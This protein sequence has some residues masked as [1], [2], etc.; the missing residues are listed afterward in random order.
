MRIDHAGCSSAV[1]L[2]S[3]GS[4]VVVTT[5]K[6][7]QV[8]IVAMT[9]N[10]G[11]GATA[12]VDSSGRSGVD[13]EVQD[14]DRVGTEF[15]LHS[16]G[17]GTGS[18]ISIAVECIFITLANGSIVCQVVGRVQG[19][20]HMI[21]DTVYASHVDIGMRSCECAI[22]VGSRHCIGI[23]GQ[24]STDDSVRVGLA[25]TPSEGTVLNNNFSRI[26]SSFGIF[27]LDEQFEAHLREGV[28]SIGGEDKG[29]I[30]A[31]GPQVAAGLVVDVTV[32]GV[33][34]NKV[35]G[36]DST[37]VYVEVVITIFEVIGTADVG[38]LTGL[39]R[40]DNVCGVGQIV[41]IAAT[42]GVGHNILVAGNQG[43]TGIH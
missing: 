25:I 15:R 39:G 27:A 34:A 28:V 32:A 7:G 23:V 3:K 8:G 29:H 37:T 24:T 1:V 41:G 5:S 12:I 26:G 19:Q 4:A 33:A 35:V 13:L 21:G 9:G 22:H 43:G 38:N 42:S 14:T 16:H 17:I 6:Q 10:L 30:T 40:T 20:F 18:S 11:H 31:V 36:V 2:P